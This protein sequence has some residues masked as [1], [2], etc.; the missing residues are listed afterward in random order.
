MLVLENNHCYR[1]LE[2]FHFKLLVLVQILNKFTLAWL[3]IHFKVITHNVVIFRYKFGDE[4]LTFFHLWWISL[5]NIICPFGATQKSWLTHTLRAKNFLQP[6]HLKRRWRGLYL[7]GI[8]LLC[9]I[10]NEDNAFWSLP[11]VRFCEVLSSI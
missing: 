1:F 7:T 9:L 11:M 10:L 2:I 3:H 6:N 5:M 8:I 4:V